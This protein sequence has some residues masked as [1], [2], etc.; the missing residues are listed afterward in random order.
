MARLRT[1]EKVYKE[2]MAQKE[3]EAIRKLEAEDPKIV[4]LNG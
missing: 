1:Y 4:D 2:M 3:N